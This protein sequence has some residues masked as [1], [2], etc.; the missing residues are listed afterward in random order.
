MKRYLLPALAVVVSLVVMGT[1]WQA[2]RYETLAE[3]AHDI[4]S[5]QKDWVEQ[6]RKLAAGIAVLSSRERAAAMAASLGLQKA[7][8]ARRLMIVVPRG[9]GGGGNG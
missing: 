4:E 6:N 2:V 7:T 8:P 1:V 5:Q 3:S 9:V